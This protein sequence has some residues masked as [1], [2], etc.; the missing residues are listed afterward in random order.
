MMLLVVGALI[1][2]FALQSEAQSAQSS[3]DLR[4]TQDRIAVLRTKA[5][6]GEPQ[7]QVDLGMAYASG[8]GVPRDETE[9]VKWFRKAAEQKHPAGEYALGE[10][11]L[12]GRGV[13]LD[14]AEAVKWIRLSAEHGYPQG[15]FNLAAMYLEGL[16]LPKDDIK[17]AEWLHKA[18]QEGFAPG[19]FG[20]GV[21]Y[22]HGRGVRR[23]LREAVRWY[24]EAGAQGYSD[25]W[26]NLAFLLA[27]T[28]DVTFRN[29]KAAV[30]AAKRA[31][32]INPRNAA[33]LDTLATAHYEAGNYDDALR[34]QRE[35]V[36]LAPEK[37]SYKTALQKYLD[38]VASKR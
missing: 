4:E 30:T 2:S 9:A 12:T 23:D 21:M 14:Q 34:I 8:D 28:S 13:S 1:L 37:Q 18:A 33:Y 36:A 6:A 5:A 20:L 19:Q 10:M 27:T 16:G 26:N 38:A 24:K 35:A 29:P 17:A 31:L 11:Y 7:A 15:Q 25:A 3:L 32:E 22:A